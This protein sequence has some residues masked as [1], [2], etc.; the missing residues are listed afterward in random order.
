M[1]HHK[2]IFIATLLTTMAFSAHAIETVI[3]FEDQNTIPL[4][5]SIPSLTIGDV[6]FSTNETLAI[7]NSFNTFEPD[8]SGNYLTNSAFGGFTELKIDFSTPIST[9]SFNFGDNQNDWEL[10]AFDTTGTALDSIMIN[11][12]PISGSNNGDFFGLSSDSGISFALLTNKGLAFQF[13][14]VDNVEF[15]N[16]KYTKVSP[17]PEPSTYALMLG[18]LGLV[19][20]MAY[21]RRKTISA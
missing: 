16:L 3:D 12:L 6:T 5:N 7:R 4:I 21:R 13:G 1:K 8:F 20:F 10:T 17:V 2:K 11:A 14:A 18:G 19:G 9:F 15:D